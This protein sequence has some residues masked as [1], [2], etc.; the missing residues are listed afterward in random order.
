[1]VI[2]L[3]GGAL[4]S[5]TSQ[6]SDAETDELVISDGK[7][8]ESENDAYSDAGE[9][10]TP[11]RRTTRSTAAGV[12]DKKQLTL[13]FSPKKTRSR[14]VVAL[15]DSSEDEISAARVTPPRRRSTRSKKATKATLDD[16]ETYEDQAEESDEFIQGRSTKPA[17]KKVVRG[18]ASRPA[19]GHFR[20]VAD[21]DYDEDED[22]AVLRAHRD[23]CEKCERKPAHL[24]LLAAQKT[25]GKKRRKSRNSHEEEEED[26]NE[27]ERINSLGGWVRWCVFLL[28]LRRLI[29]YKFLQSQMPTRCS[30]G[31]FVQIAA[32]RNPA[33]CARKG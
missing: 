15:S 21:L 3:N 26:E 16:D 4:I 27:E 6:V 12:H 28:V 8:S 18:K 20:T 5:H 22:T 25:Q 29:T 10:D 7:H 11:L 32:R 23:F 1:M 14:K 13:P 17:K 19:Y 24:L 30:L 2:K 31:L 9:S 33:S